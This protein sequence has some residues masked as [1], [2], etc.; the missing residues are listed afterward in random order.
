MSSVF[1][2]IARM[3]RQC[4]ASWRLPAL[5]VTSGVDIRNLAKLRKLKQYAVNADVSGLVKVS[6][7]T[8]MKDK[9][10]QAYRGADRVCWYFTAQDTPSRIF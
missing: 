10:E 4:F 2:S 3:H 9:A 7:G 8:A 5:I 1:I 6:N